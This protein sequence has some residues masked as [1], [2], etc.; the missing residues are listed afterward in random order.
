MRRANKTFLLAALALAGCAH[1]PA[2]KPAT[3]AAPAAFSQP[4][5]AADAK[6]AEAFG[7]PAL[8]ELLA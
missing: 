3:P 7:D 4:G 1:D 6:W 5:A 2:A 8:I